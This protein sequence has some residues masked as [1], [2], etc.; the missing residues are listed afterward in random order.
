MSRDALPFVC[1]D[2]RIECR[3]PQEH[4]ECSMECYTII[5]CPLHRQAG[6][7]RDLLQ[8]FKEQNYQIKTVD[9]DDVDR[10][11]AATQKPR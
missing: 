11:L 7:L 10:V 2:C 3:Q 8:R 6:A 9:T 1:P 4:P 5:F